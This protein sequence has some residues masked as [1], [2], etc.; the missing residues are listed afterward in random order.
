MSFTVRQANAD[1]LDALV[2]MRMAFLAEVQTGTSTVSVDELTSRVRASIAAMMAAGDL[3]AWFAE[4]EAEAIG[5]SMAVFHRRPPSYGNPSGVDAYIMSVY[6]V[7]EWR[8]RGV[9]RRLL[10][11]TL[12]YLRGTEATNA[13]LHATDM[14]RAVYEKLGFAASEDAMMLKLRR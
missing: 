11:A 4:V 3:V 12:D 1:D 8:R 6:T 10:T 5:L 9:S 7:P 2:D 14:G 13:V